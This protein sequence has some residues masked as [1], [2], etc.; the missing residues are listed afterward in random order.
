MNVDACRREEEIGVISRMD[1]GSS[2][3][4]PFSILYNVSYASFIGRKPSFSDPDKQLASLAEAG[5]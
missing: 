4:M 3:S 2:E 5:I 1:N